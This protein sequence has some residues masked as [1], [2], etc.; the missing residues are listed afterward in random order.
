MNRGPNINDEYFTFIAEK[1]QSV[2]E[3]YVFY[4]HLN[5]SIYL[6]SKYVHASKRACSGFL[7]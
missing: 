7:T 4:L 3:D 6:K 5:K 2:F 1:S